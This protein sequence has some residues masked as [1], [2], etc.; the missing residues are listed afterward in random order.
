[1]WL[2]SLVGAVSCKPA[3]F[4]PSREASQLHQ[5]RKAIDAALLTCSLQVVPYP[6][7]A[8]GTVAKFEAFSNA[9]RQP[10][11]GL[12]VPAGR[13]GEPLVEPAGRNVRSPAHRP[14]RPHISMTNDKGVLHCGSLA[15]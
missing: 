5:A 6:W 8:V 2:S 13:P 10:R 9:P 1:M 11:I 7:V 15:K 14:R 3:A 12:A 4:A